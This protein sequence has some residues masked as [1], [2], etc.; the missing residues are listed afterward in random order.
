MPNGHL[1]GFNTYLNQKNDKYNYQI[2][3]NF[4]NKNNNYKFINNFPIIKEKEE[5]KQENIHSKKI[6]LKNNK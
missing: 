2:K 3:T 4:N 6:K 1:T 5:F